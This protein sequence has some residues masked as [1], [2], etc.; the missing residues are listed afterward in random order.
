MFSQA[1]PAG[2]HARAQL[3]EIQAHPSLCS[4]C[5]ALTALRPPKAK[6]RD[7]P[8]ILESSIKGLVEESDIQRGCTHTFALQSAGSK[9][10]T[11]LLNSPADPI[12]LRMTGISRSAAAYTGP[13]AGCS[14]QDG[15]TM[16]PR[17]GTEGLRCH[18]RPSRRLALLGKLVLAFT[19][20]GHA[21]VGARNA[22]AGPM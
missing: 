14:R 3:L 12:G 10:W 1:A 19:F 20:P 7:W 4:S 16:S 13:A 15:A 2:S 18:G 22:L 21:T 9:Y 8:E 11:N 5:Y 6:A 17:Y